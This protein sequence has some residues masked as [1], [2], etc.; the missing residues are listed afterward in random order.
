MKDLFPFTAEAFTCP[1]H[2]WHYSLDAWT[3]MN[4]SLTHCF[5]LQKAAGTVEHPEE[6][7]CFPRKGCLPGEEDFGL[8]PRAAPVYAAHLASGF[9]HQL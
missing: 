7:N 2:T 8:Q 6:K 4:P 1:T 9:S 5:A 3:Q